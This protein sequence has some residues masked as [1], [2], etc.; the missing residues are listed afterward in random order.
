MIKNLILSSGGIHGYCYIGSFK[1]L[2]ENNLLGNIENILGTSAG[3]IFGLLYILGFNLF[4]I[5]ELTTKILPT[6]WLDINYTSILNFFDDYGI[7][8][9]DK[10]IKI[11]KI[12]TNRKLDKP[13]LTFKELYEYSK[14]NFIVSSVNVNKQ[15]QIYFNHENYPDMPIYKAIRMSTS[16][17]LL[18]K[19]YKFENELYVDGGIIDPCSV[20]YFNNPKETL[21]LM[22][23]GR[24]YED[25]ASFRDFIICLYCCPIEKVRE[26]SYD[27]PNIIIFNIKDIKSLN[28]EITDEN[29]KK[30]IQEG[31]DIT[32]E[33]LPD[34]IEYFE[35]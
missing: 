19:P 18:F 11:I 7:E 20:N 25:L 10:M 6:Q 4:E 32:Q 21:V 29:I 14:I 17:P 16:I 9:G 24:K 12:I 28:F 35:K 27:K 5:E 31:Y 3:S 30:I 2:I 26:E 13:E 33:E 1:Y 34:I 8:E 22:I 15:K 23:S